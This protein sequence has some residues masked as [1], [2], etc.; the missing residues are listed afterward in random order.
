MWKFQQKTDLD[1]SIHALEG[2]VSDDYLE[3]DLEIEEDFID[4]RSHQR[5]AFAEEKNDLLDTKELGNIRSHQRNTHVEEA[6]DEDD[7]LLTP[8]LRYDDDHF[9]DWNGHFLLL[10]DFYQKTTEERL[11]FVIKP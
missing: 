3:A 2:K 8:E 10:K 5:D 6:V 1:S 7:D 9:T 11:C 4:L